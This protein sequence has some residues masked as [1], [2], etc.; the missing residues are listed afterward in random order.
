MQKYVCV[1]VKKCVSLSLSLSLLCVC[2]CVCVCVS[3]Y[4]NIYRLHCMFEGGTEDDYIIKEIQVN[5]V[6]VD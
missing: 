2:V 4:I 6:E 3:V 1:Y 5:C